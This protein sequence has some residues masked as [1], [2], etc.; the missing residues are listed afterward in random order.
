M[1]AYV[2]CRTTRDRNARG[3]GI[4]VYDV[5]ADGKWTQ[6]QCLP[7]EENPSYL[8]LDHTGRNLY[9][10]HGDLTKASSFLVQDDGTLE[11]LNT[12]D[13]GGRNPVDISLD[14]D[15]RYVIVAT[16]QG[17]TLYTISRQEN[18][19][20]G[21][22]VAKYTFE[23]KE[24]GKV[25]T[26]HQCYWDKTGN[27]MISCA[28]GRINGY[29][30]VRAMRYDSESG[31]FRKTAQFLARTWDEPR[32]VAIHEN[33]RWLYM[34]EEKGNKVR[35]FSFN[36]E[37]G[38]LE[39]LQELSTVPE[40]EIRYSDASE[41]MISPGGKYVLASNR[42]TDTMV[43]YRIDQ[44]TGYLKLHGFHDCL[45]K[46]PRFF[47][48]DPAGRCYVAGEDS[49]NIVEFAWDESSGRL[50]AAGNEIHCGSPTCI[51]FK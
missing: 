21:E 33:N 47:C 40:T 19:A 27:Y 26:V 24:E 41:V 14:R 1:I 38:S 16:L 28:Q 34:V 10:V 43:V 44:N 29:G 9:C 45:C 12:I 39:A 30:Q 2:G 31:E 48:F 51:I 11:H 8:C 32:H 20:L 46:T 50:T 37:D 7:I 36:P 25:S 23:G 13:I 49:D 3:E 42:Y 35:Y 4:L 17:G 5:D 18:G 15:N 6:K 22:I